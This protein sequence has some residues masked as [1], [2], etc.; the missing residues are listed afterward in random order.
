MHK[1]H[2]RIQAGFSSGFTT[3]YTLSTLFI[4][5]W[6][7]EIACGSGSK[8]ASDFIKSTF[9]CIHL[10]LVDYVNQ[11]R[12]EVV[13]PA[14]PAPR[15]EDPRTGEVFGIKP[16]GSAS[17]SMTAVDVLKDLQLAASARRRG[18]S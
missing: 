7:M 9:G 18:H 5:S 3:M 10:G 16:L 12:N 17:S 13:K 14:V 2:N 15:L 8:Y 11:L 6:N 1:H 4:L